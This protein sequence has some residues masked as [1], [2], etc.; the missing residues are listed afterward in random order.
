MAPCDGTLV[1]AAEE[2]ETEKCGRS[3]VFLTD[4]I[5]R[6]IA[7]PGTDASEPGEP[8]VTSSEPTPEEFQQFV[9]ETAVTNVGD[10]DRN[11]G[12]RQRH[13]GDP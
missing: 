13:K 2:P 4:R 8:M 1:A 9:K 7:V 5:P 6:P 3:A 11:K 10:H 12:Y